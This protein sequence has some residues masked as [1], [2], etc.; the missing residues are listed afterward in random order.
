ML[1]YF[2]VYSKVVQLYIY[3]IFFFKFFSCIDCDRILSRVPVLREL[4]L[5]AL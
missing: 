4:K 5:R 1:Y 3:I 2:H